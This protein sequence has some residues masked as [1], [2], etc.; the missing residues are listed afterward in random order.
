MKK[1]ILI[2]LSAICLFASACKKDKQTKKDEMYLTATKDNAKWVTNWHTFG[3]V[4]GAK[5]Y[6][7][8]GTKGEEH[9]R[10]R[11]TTNSLNQF[12]L[13]TEKTEFHITI[14]LDAVA[15]RYILDESTENIVDITNYDTRRVIMEGNFKLK[16]K[17]LSGLDG[18]PATVTFTDGKFKVS[19][20]YD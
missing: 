12:V 11:V 14:G 6:I 3:E 5:N 4:D 15:A 7:L 8:L 10:V 20:A 19:Q 16:F 2:V 9:L 18:Y 1:L 13:D 17:K